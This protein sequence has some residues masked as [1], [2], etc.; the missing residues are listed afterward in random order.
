MQVNCVDVGKIIQFAINLQMIEYGD[1]HTMRR[2]KKEYG[3]V[4]RCRPAPV[5]EVNEAFPWVPPA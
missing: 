4:N 2:Y 1:F 3:F 5:N